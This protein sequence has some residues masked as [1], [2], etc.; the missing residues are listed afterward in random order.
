M[1]K[2]EPTHQSGKKNTKPQNRFPNYFGKEF[3]KI[4]HMSSLVYHLERNRESGL[5]FVRVFVLCGFVLPVSL[6]LNANV[7]ENV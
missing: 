7:M 6:N 4:D 2:K 5:K 1:L 3:T